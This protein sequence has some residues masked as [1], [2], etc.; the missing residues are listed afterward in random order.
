MPNHPPAREGPDTPSADAPAAPLPQQAPAPDQVPARA[1]RPPN[2]QAAPLPIKKEQPPEIIDVDALS[3]SSESQASD[4]EDEDT[5]LHE[6]DD[7]HIPQS[8]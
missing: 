7:D 8:M 5:D 6:T 1:L 3:S 4:E 2:H